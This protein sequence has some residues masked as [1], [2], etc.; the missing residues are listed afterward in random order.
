[1]QPSLSLVLPIRNA[2][3]SVRAQVERLLDLLSDLAPRF[4]VLLVD[5]ASTDHTAEIA[6]ELARQYPQVRLIRFEQPRGRDEVLASVSDR[7]SGEVVLIPPPGASLA[8]GELRGLWQEQ[9]GRQSGVP[10][11]K[12][13]PKPLGKELLDRLTT[14]GQR[15]DS[16]L[17][18]APP[19]PIRRPATF[20]AHLRALTGGE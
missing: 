13:G 8:A 10:S 1:L 14:W 7:A 15:L 18:E 20:L 3:N 17:P 5:D 11:L 16:D 12:Q 2:E 6:Q 4:E 19:A 9:A